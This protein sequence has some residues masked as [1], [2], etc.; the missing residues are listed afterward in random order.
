MPESV[1]AAKQKVDTEGD[2]W[3][4]TLSVSEQFETVEYVGMGI[5]SKSFLE[6]I[7]WE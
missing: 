3:S 6:R 4:D 2:E 7:L 1:L 5:W